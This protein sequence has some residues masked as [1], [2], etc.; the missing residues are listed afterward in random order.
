M[1]PVPIIAIFSFCLDIFHHEPE[2]ATIREWGGTDSD[3][4]I[5]VRAYQDNPAQCT[6][7]Q[8]CCRFRPVFL[9]YR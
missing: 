6:I 5:P 1:K 7:L 3:F 8:V 2:L 9:E 4:F